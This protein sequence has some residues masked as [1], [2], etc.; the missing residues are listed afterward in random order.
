MKTSVRGLS[1]IASLAALAFAAPVFAAVYAPIEDAELLRRA[2]TVVVARATGSTVVATPGGLPE[3]RTTFT[4]IDSLAGSDD[5][6]FE[7]AVPGGELPG[8]L[9]LALEGAPRFTP[10]GLYVLALNAR[11]DGAFVP[12][13]AG[14]RRVR[15]GAGRGGAHLRDP[16]DVPLRARGRA[17]ARGRRVA[18][19]APRAPAR[20]GRLHELRACRALPRGAARRRAGLRRGPRGG[21]PEAGAPGRRL[22][23]VG[24]P[25]VP[26]RR[27]RVVRRRT[28]SAIAGS[29]RRRRCAGPTRT[30][31][32]SAS[33]ASRAAGR[34][35]SR[36]RSRSG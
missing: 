28:S 4:A 23:P 3:T 10:G 22:G 31:R 15:R 17:A 27:S 29:T 9:T 8:G 7:V 2:N 35:S 1:L 5:P 13:R 24:R 26:E 14:A 34:S 16:R 6:Y 19:R 21:Q 20:A 33:G 25:L 12:D 32:P 30:P 11:A 18:E 36:M